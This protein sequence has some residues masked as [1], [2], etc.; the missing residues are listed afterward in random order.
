[1]I[2]LTNKY[3]PDYFVLKFNAVALRCDLYLRSI[4]LINHKGVFNSRLIT[5]SEFE[6]LKFVDDKEEF[7]VRMQNLL[8]YLDIA[9]SDLQSVYARNTDTRFA[10]FETEN[11]LVEMNKEL[12]GVRDM[13]DG[14]V[15]W[16]TYN[17]KRPI[18]TFEDHYFTAYKRILKEIRRYA[19]LPGQMASFSH[20]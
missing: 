1:M 14:M 2:L 6:E 10:I 11:K 7:I 18:S 16:A 8:Q 9:Q 5:W 3:Q 12:C 19:D 15:N 4:D 17:H 20:H 13:T